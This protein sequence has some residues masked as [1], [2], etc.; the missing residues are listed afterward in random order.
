MKSDSLEPVA[1]LGPAEIREQLNNLSEHPVF[2]GSRRCVLLLEYLVEYALSG[3]TTPPKERQLG[4]EI[5]G[6][7]PDYDTS[8]DPVVRSAAGEVRKRIAQYYQEP[9]HES[10]LHFSLP[11]GSY[12]LEFQWPGQA[13]SPQIIPHVP[14]VR[15][16]LSVRLPMAA[17]ILVTVAAVAIAAFVFWAY[18]L[19]N[20]A[21]LVRFW[22]PVFVANHVVVCV[23]PSLTTESSNI[24]GSPNVQTAASVQPS[25]VEGRLGI[26]F[27][28][29]NE[30]LAV[31]QIIRFLDSNNT[32]FE[33]QFPPAKQDV[34][35]NY[36]LPGLGESR[37]DAAVFIGT[38]DWSGQL[39]APLRFSVQSDQPG[40]T[41]WIKDMQQPLDR[42]WSVKVDTPYSEY[43]KDYALITRVYDPTTREPFVLIN[44]VGLY[45][46]AAAADFVT[47]PNIMGQVTAKLGHKW[48]EKN[49]QIVIS[50]RVV[51]NS[52][53]NPE[54]LTEYFW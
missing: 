48:Q 41:I 3:E 50:V 5:F 6:R 37:G 47:N 29:L 26:P 34:P 2:K 30:S 12:L 11:L 35:K 53:A 21:P 15:T 19:R 44:G 17:A 46:T 27:V 31:V 52:W 1:P 40:G 8:D 43:E 16:R 10:E 42:R 7:D 49:M 32:K 24:T 4:I 38:S 28:R 18:K 14:A 33:I 13:V 51:G 54:I 20:P 36:I 39:L 25:S 9:G 45:G 23:Q 22:D